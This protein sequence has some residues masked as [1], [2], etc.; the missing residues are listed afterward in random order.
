MKL[1]KESYA[2][3]VYAEQATTYLLELFLIGNIKTWLGATTI[4]KITF[5]TMTLSVIKFHQMYS[6]W[7][8]KM[9]RVIII[10]V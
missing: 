8:A 2:V 4:S 9:L 5:S 7:N 1:S 6:M 10:I 3:L